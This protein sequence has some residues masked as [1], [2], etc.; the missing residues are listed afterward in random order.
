MHYTVHHGDTLGNIASRYGVSVQA[1]MHANGLHHTMI[2]PGQRLSD[3][4]SP[5]LLST[6]CT[7]SLLRRAPSLKTKR[8]P[9][10]NVWVKR[11]NGWFYKK[12]NTD[13]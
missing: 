11:Q 13:F 4:S 6:P 8:P 3:S 12:A 7:T 5:P 10:W 9:A 2:Y 1:I